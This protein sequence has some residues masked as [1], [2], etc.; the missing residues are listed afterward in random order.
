MGDESLSDKIGHFLSYA[1]LGALAALARLRLFATFPAA[2]AL[3]TGYGLAIEALQGLGG[4]RTPDLW[5]G[6]AD[7]LGAALGVG[8][9]KALFP[10]AKAS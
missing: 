10:A 1:V 4:V 8:A 6:S 5:D 7:A 3:L 2:V 9:A